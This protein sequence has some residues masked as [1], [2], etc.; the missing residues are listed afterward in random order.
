MVHA[1]RLPSLLVALLPMTACG[2][3]AD[4]FKGPASTEPTADFT[5]ADTDGDWHQGCAHVSDLNR[6]MSV[7]RDLHIAAGA[8]ERHDQYFSDADCTKPGYDV[9]MSGSFVVGDPTRTG[10]RGLALG[11][12]GFVVTV[13][14]AALVEAMRLVQYCAISDWAADAP[15][16]VPAAASCRHFSPFDGVD[17]GRPINAVRLPPDG[18]GDG[19][20]LKLTHAD[21]G[22]EIMASVDEWHREVAPADAAS[23]AP[24]QYLEVPGHADFSV[25][26]ELSPRDEAHVAISFTFVPND[27][28]AL[29]ALPAKEP[30][31]NLTVGRVQWPRACAEAGKVTPSSSVPATFRWLTDGGDACAQLSLTAEGLSPEACQRLL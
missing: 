8:F 11:I 25:I 5:A 14:D 28:D 24:C 13:Q 17:G 23:A 7:L 19:R 1:L 29:H 15:R 3:L 27:P 30:M 31:A 12:D 16:E 6:G 9:A 22:N 18:D 4:V 26:D 10:A 20:K 2:E 21:G